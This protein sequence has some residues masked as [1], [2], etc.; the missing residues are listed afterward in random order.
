LRINYFLKH[1][2]KGKLEG[3]LE[4]I[5]RRGIRLKQLLDDLK[6]NRGYRKLEE[7]T[8]DLAVRRIRF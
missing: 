3:R 4:V 1:V 5:G 7:E 6:D 8:V 2:T